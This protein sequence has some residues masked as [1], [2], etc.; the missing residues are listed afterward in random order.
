M[1]TRFFLHSGFLAKAKEK[2]ET[3]GHKIQSKM[4]APSGGSSAGH[5]PIQTQ[6]GS[7]RASKRPE[8]IV[9]QVTRECKPG[10]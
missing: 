6:P 8:N 3:V 10:I 4:D 7:G 2:A 1:I 5:P 9:I